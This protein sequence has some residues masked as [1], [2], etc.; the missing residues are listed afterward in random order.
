MCPHLAHGE[1]Q[2]TQVRKHVLDNQHVR[3]LVEHLHPHDHQVK[4][5]PL[6][7]QAQ[8]ETADIAVVIDEAA[9]V[10]V[11][12]V[13]VAVFAYLGV[14]DELVVVVVAAVVV[15]VVGVVSVVMVLVVF[16]VLLLWWYGTRIVAHTRGCGCRSLSLLSPSTLQ[17]WKSPSCGYGRDCR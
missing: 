4:C 10:A 5:V 2:G 8:E 17:T 3:Q 1:R 9:V 6:P 12:G 7:A 13:A 11:I 14:P 16:V 15:V